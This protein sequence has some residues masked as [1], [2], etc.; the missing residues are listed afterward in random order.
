MTQ[1]LTNEALHKK[2]PQEI[3]A[4]LY[5]ACYNNLELA[6]KAIDDKEFTKANDFLQKANDIIYRLG[7]GINYE[8][9]IVADQ[10]DSIYNYM[11]DQLIQANYTKNAELVKVVLNLLTEIMT[12]WNQAM[13]KNTD[14]QPKTIKQKANAYEQTSIYE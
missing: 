13:K 6:I 10:L 12:A 7:G 5:E 9:G 8:A 4:L 1:I 14:I 3:T 2:S 11:A